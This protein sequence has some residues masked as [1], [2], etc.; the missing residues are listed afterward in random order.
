MSN[1]GTFGDITK[2]SVDSIPKH[3]ILCAGFPCQPFLV[4]SVKE[5]F[6]HPTQN[7][8]LWDCAYHKR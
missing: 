5:G 7:Y 1:F 2:I 3:D 6:E 8:V 4:I